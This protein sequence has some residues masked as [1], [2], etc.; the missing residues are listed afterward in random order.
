[1]NHFRYF[2]KKTY[3]HKIHLFEIELNFLIRTRNRKKNWIA[4]IGDETR[5]EHPEL[6]KFQFQTNKTIPML[7]LLMPRCG[8][9]D[10]KRM[11]LSSAAFPLQCTYKFN[12]FA[13]YLFS[14][15]SCFLF[16]VRLRL[17]QNFWSKIMWRTA[18]KQNNRW[19]IVSL[20][21]VVSSISWKYEH[22]H[23]DIYFSFFL[24]CVFVLFCTFIS[25]TLNQQKAHR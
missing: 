8:Q 10:N 15:K 3:I 1:M 12:W 6:S 24:V 22:F 20:M 18:N 23:S 21:F 16:T 13:R 14:I 9:D 2:K 4:A 19:K 5:I 25:L 7:S 17:V 11:P